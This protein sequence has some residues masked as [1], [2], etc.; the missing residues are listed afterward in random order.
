MKT[1]ELVYRY[2]GLDD[3]SREL[4]K[5]ICG[6]SP[7]VEL[8]P[9][10]KGLSGSTVLMGRWLLKSGARSKFHVFK[11]GCPKKLRRES[12]AIK[13]I[14]SKLVSSLSKPDYRVSPDKSR[15]ILSQE[16]MGDSV[17]SNRSLRQYIEDAD[18]ESKVTD[19]LNRIYSELIKWAPVEAPP[20][21]DTTVRKE[22]SIW[23]AKVKKE[24]FDRALYD[25]GNIALQES[26]SDKFGLTLSGLE[27]RLRRVF[28]SKITIQRGA[29]HGDLHA[30]NVIIDKDGRISLIDFGWTDVRWRA[31]DYIWLECSLKFV[32]SSPYAILEDLLEMDKLLDDAWNNKSEINTTL[33]DG[34]MHAANLKKIASGV[35]FIRQHARTHLPTLSLQ[36]YRKGLVAMSYALTTV[37]KLNR[38]YLIHSIARNTLAL[39]DD[40]QSEGPY[41]RLYQASPLLWSS[42]PGRMVKKA[43]GHFKLPGQALDIG[44]G[45]G[46][47]LVYLEKAGW[48]VTGFDINSIAIDSVEKR[49]KQHLG[50]RGKTSTPVFRADAR[51]YDY[52]SEL[53]DLA[54]CRT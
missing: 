37:P 9:L 28:D 26:I 15:A 50:E 1:D 32:V 27:S 16:F 44:C 2:F 33:F 35:S 53:F 29:V 21:V 39:D 41:H 4:L 49:A 40:L 34:K 25:L 54:A 45:D 10:D 19:I 38:T 3:H 20:T 31:I 48:K 8:A 46:K 24:D 6:K 43:L 14:A 5:Q 52:P 23:I 12:R 17:S 42:Q 47:N 13:S 36:D 18:N 30:Q 11:I 22:F 51:K 7:W